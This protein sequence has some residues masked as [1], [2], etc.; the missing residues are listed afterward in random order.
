MMYFLSYVFCK[1]QDKISAKRLLFLN[2]DKA[3]L[4]RFL[5]HKA[6]TIAQQS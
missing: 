5:I 2:H 1:L 4:R 6:T 3:N